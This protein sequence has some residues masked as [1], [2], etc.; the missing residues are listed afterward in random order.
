MGA[1]G[2]IAG[3]IVGGVISYNAQQNAAKNRT[4][5]IED[6]ARKLREANEEYSGEKANQKMT[7]RGNAE[8]NMMRQL[9]GA[10]TKAYSGGTQYAQGANA[11]NDIA[12]TL[13]SA[14]TT[15]YNLGASNEAQENAAQLK[16]TEK[17]IQNQLKQ[18]D[19]EY[20][21]DVAKTQ[22]IIN[23]VSGLVDTANKIGNPFKGT[24]GE[25]GPDAWKDDATWSHA[26]GFDASF[27]SDEN[28]KEPADDGI[29][30]EKLL[31][32]IKDFKNLKYK[33]DRFTNLR[34]WNKWMR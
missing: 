23:G 10:G 32:A 14:T 15:G 16:K 26:D 21:A 31:K 33:V 13:S 11:A 3:A 2:A 28:M 9:S 4:R 12:N 8:A 20:N 30:D 25:E 7:A 29:D 24:G 5:A 22:G 1:F 27:N 17:E 19:I 34:K 6:A 18:A